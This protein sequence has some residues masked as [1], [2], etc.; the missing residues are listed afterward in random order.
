MH[1]LRCD[2][3]HTHTRILYALINGY[4]LYFSILMT[5][6]VGWHGLD[7]FSV[8]SSTLALRLAEYICVSVNVFTTQE[9]VLLFFDR[10]KCTSLSEW[11]NTGKKSHTN[12]DTDTHTHTNICHSL[13]SY[14]RQ[15]NAKESWRFSRCRA[16]FFLS[17]SI[18]IEIF[19]GHSSN[20]VW[21]HTPFR[22]A[23]YV[24][25]AVG[26]RARPKTEKSYTLRLFFRLKMLR[27]QKMDV[28]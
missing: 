19:P 13:N 20:S 9:N 7:G 23:K 18:W 15:N 27:M 2:L 14:N 17:F 1:G 3:K 26:C 5:G 22:V 25:F 6:L 10:V 4:I 24:C 12:T 21:Q 16:L 8:L 28:K 11:E